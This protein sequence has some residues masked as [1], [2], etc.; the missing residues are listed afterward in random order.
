VTNDTLRRVLDQTAAGVVITNRDGIIEYVN[1]AYEAITGFTR[2]EAIGRSP[3]MVQSGVQ[4]PIFYDTLWAAIGSGRAFHATLTNRARDGHLFQYEQ[5]ITP[6]V[7]DRHGI[8]H[9]AA[10]GRD[11]TARYRSESAR[12]LVQLEDEATRVA[13]LLHEGAG[14][15]LALA[16]IT[17]ADVSRSLKAADAA[18]VLEVRGYL[19]H[20]EQQLREVSRGIQPRVVSDLGL[21]EALRFVAAGY[22]SRH[23]VTVTVDA[24]LDVE[25]PASIESLLY[26]FVRDTLVNVG[27][28]AHATQVSIVLA[29]PVNGRRAHDKTVSCTVRDNGIGFDV[30]HLA[31][32]SGGAL[33]SLQI[34]F[35]AI[36]GTLAVVST[37]G[38]GTEVCATVPVER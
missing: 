32:L 35:G 3:N 29:R 34:R 31:R 26:A 18:R 17:L 5:T 16:H 8:T 23:G 21:V 2:D 13:G 7:D 11:V 15:F 20:I 19:D 4:T 14:Q 33:K 28:H 12:L 6:I 30:S 22:E 9:F 38:S 24:A 1:S 36:G 27:T 10:I 25:C 37:P